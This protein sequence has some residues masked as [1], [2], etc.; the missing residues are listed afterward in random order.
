MIRAL[1]ITIYIRFSMMFLYYVVYSAIAYNIF[2]PLLIQENY[3]G[4]LFFYD[5]VIIFGLSIVSSYLFN[6]DTKGASKTTLST[7]N[8]VTDFNTKIKPYKN[9]ERL[10]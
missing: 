7:G 6:K 1:W 5:K 9:G 10:F 4:F 3:K 2:L 8:D